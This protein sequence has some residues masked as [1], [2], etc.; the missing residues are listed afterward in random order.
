MLP[1]LEEPDAGIP[2]LDPEPGFPGTTMA[3]TSATSG[4]LTIYVPYEA[5]VTINGLDTKSTGSRR[6]YV[7]YGL[8]PGYTYEYTIR[9]E[10]VR[11]GKPLS[12]E[13][14]V[15]LT[16]GARNAVAFGFNTPNTEN[17]AAK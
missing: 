10:I 6:E 2:G 16:A 4:L 3:P 1:G 7:S 14:T 12:D 5:K 8:K 15:V 9:A 17:L 11:D 13:R